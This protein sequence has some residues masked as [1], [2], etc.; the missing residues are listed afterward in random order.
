M[1]RLMTISL[2]LSLSAGGALA[3]DCSP[4]RFGSGESGA[5]V[6]GVLPAEGR[7]CYTLDV[8]RGQRVTI[9]LVGG[10]DNVA[11]TVLDVGDARESFDFAAP[12]NRVEFLVFQLMRSVT[13]A[14]Y[15]LHIQVQ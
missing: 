8:R 10:S 9:A 5:L 11:V 4:I 6:D 14:D 3:Q 15:S 7:D 1:L 2:C 12:S 13:T